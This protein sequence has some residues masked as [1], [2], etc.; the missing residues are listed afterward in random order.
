MG[1]RRHCTV[2]HICPRP[3]RPTISHI[4]DM[5]PVC[6]LAATLK[7]ATSFLLSQPDRGL[8]L[9]CIISIT[10]ISPGQ[11]GTFG[12]SVGTPSRGTGLNFISFCYSQLVAWCWAQ[13]RTCRVSVG[14]DSQE[15]HNDVS[16]TNGLAHEVEMDTAAAPAACQW[17]GH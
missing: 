16:R 7:R 4:F 1:N 13:C 12:S 11:F 3:S 6:V 8:Q 9:H 15:R 17:S 10:S 2:R 14:Y 5:H